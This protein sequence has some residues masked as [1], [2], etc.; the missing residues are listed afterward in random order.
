MERAQDLRALPAKWARFCLSIR[1]FAALEL[2]C[3]FAALPCLVACSGGADSTAL[4]CIARLL[5]SRHGGSVRVAHLDHC[6]RPDSGED[7]RFV[8]ELC[9][10][11]G[12]PL[13]SQ[14]ADVAALA[15]ER[16]MG[17]EEA[18]RA[19]RYE[20]LKHAAAE[21]GAQ[22]VLV[23]HQLN[24]LAEDQLMR[25]ARGAGW[26]ALGGMRGFD[27]ERALLRPLLLTPRS[28]LEEFLKNSGRT[29]RVDASNADPAQ[30]RN[31]VRAHILPALVRENPA[32]LD[33]A[34]RLW[35]QARLDQAHWDAELAPLLAQ[36][37]QVDAGQAFE[38]PSAL[39]DACPAPLRLRLMK[40]A[41]Q[42]LGP[43][44]A[45]ADSLL[46]LDALW[47]QRANGKRVRFPGNKEALVAKSGLR[48]RVI[49]RKRECG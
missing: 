37:P 12:L 14:R 39:L 35:R 4:L 2:G 36:L 23:G 33:A 45:L 47:S 22:V 24:D 44:Q 3:D 26:P 49:D 40:A 17:V 41:L 5:C 9:A 6:L 10:E 15:R 18:G 48:L 7:A 19:A 27:A 16:G 34:A 32:Y 28:L 31:R 21:C 13:V 11:L 43:G 25:L 30:T 8:A 38:L 46:R 20:F 29:W 1:G 42:R